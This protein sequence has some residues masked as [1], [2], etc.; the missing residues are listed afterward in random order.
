MEHLGYKVVYDPTFDITPDRLQPERHRHEERR[1]EDPVPRADA[2]ELRRPR[3]SRPSTSRT[4]T[5]CWCSVGRPTASSWC[6]N[7]GGP[8]AIDGA[9]IEQNTALYL[10]EDAGCL[11]A[12]N[13]FLT[14]VQKASPGFKRRP[15]HPVRLAVGRAVRP[16]PQGRRPRPEPGLGAPAAPEDHL[17]LRGEPGRHGQP[18]REGAD[19]LLHHR[20]DRERQVPAAGRPAGE[21]SAHGY[22]CDQPFYYY[23]SRPEPAPVGDSAG[24]PGR[25]ARSGQCQVSALGR[26]LSSPPWAAARFISRDLRLAA[27]FLWITPLAAA[28]SIRLMARRSASSL[29]SAPSSMARWPVLVRVRSSER[30]ALLRAGA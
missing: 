27:W 12:V 18:G 2:R 23:P 11:P 4:S 8:S 3:W 25:P 14:W 7:A 26:R 15:L 22:R 28:L 9:Y 21:R 1:G 16:G 5:R 6:P 30:T 19:Q 13:T 29:S 10:G 24:G 17:V 20:P